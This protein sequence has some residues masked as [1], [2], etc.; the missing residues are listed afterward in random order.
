MAR[1]K[2]NCAE[3]EERL[4]VAGLASGRV[5]QSGASRDRVVQ[6]DIRGRQVP[7]RLHRGQVKRQR[8]VELCH[9]QLRVAV[10]Q[11]ELAQPLPRLRVGR[12]ADRW[13][14]RGRRARRPGRRWRRGS[15]T[16]PTA[17]RPRPGRPRPRSVHRR[18]PRSVRPASSSVIAEA[19]ASDE[20]SGCQT[21][22]T[23]AERDRDDRQRRCPAATGDFVSRLRRGAPDRVAQRAAPGQ[24]AGARQR[25]NRH[26]REEPGPVDRRVDPERDHHREHRDQPGPLGR[27]RLVRWRAQATPTPPSVRPAAITHA[28]NSARLS[29]VPISPKSANVSIT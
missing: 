17:R 9:R 8:L 19:S 14:A 20:R 5:G 27:E 4:R 18:A 2:S 13:R 22:Q 29:S 21:T 15:P 1:C 12:L 25:G 11:V 26:A 6:R 7:Q 28:T 23:D 10:A 3:L 16:A 24:P